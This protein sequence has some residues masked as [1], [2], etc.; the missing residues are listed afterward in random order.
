MPDA[1]IPEATPFDHHL[2]DTDDAASTIMANHKMTHLGIP[3]VSSPDGNCFFNSISIGLYGDESYTI[4]LR[5]RN[6]IQ[7][8]L[9]K[10]AYTSR[11]DV[12]D[13][14]DLSPT[15]ETATIECATAHSYSSLW[16]LIAAAAITSIYRYIL[17]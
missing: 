2:L 5:A 1:N 3:K 12:E 16:T 14:L 8:C 6:C 4:E 17:Q 15:F 13:I 11:P 9:Q 7:M 10:T